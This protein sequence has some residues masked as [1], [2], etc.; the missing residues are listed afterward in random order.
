VTES[1]DDS[2]EEQD[3]PEWTPGTR[4]LQCKLSSANTGLNDRA[5]ESPYALRPKSVQNPLRNFEKES[6]GLPLHSSTYQREL[7]QDE[8]MEEVVPLD[9]PSRH[10]YNLR[11]RTKTS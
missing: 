4:Y 6:A 3:S 2:R 11:S 1:E 10:P 5:K 7:S 8:P 9:A